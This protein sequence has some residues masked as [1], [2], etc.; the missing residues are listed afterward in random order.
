MRVY[1]VLGGGGWR[2][3]FFAILLRYTCMRLS[4]QSRMGRNKKEGRSARSL[5]GNNL[6]SV[7]AKTL[8][9]GDYFEKV[10]EGIAKRAY[11]GPQ[12]AQQHIREENCHAGHCKV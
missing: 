5:S 6:R 2:H 8:K 12:T 9:E 4:R 10:P 3:R 7:F 11:R 1:T